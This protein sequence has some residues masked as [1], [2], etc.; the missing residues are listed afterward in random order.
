MRKGVSVSYHQLNQAASRFIERSSLPASL[1]E[2]S[3]RTIEYILSQKR[4][5]INKKRHGIQD[6][7]RILTNSAPFLAITLSA[8]IRM[9]FLSLKCLQ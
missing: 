4:L 1:H 3:Q 9:T 8:C 7:A 5:Q 6:T 2:G